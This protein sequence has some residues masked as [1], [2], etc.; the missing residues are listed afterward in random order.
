MR[1]A[2]RTAFR[3]I[4]ISVSVK[5]REIGLLQFSHL[6]VHC[7]DISVFLS[8]LPTTMRILLDIFAGAIGSA[9]LIS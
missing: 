7:A 3:E 8:A 1:T 5:I 4:G 2:K 6:S 9:G